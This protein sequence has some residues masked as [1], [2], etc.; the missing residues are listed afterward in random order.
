MDTTQTQSTGERLGTD[1]LGR[2][3]HRC[4]DCGTTEGAPYT[5]NLDG[6]H[7]CNVCVHLHDAEHACL[8]EAAQRILDAL[9]NLVQQA[10]HYMPDNSG[11]LMHAK[12]V[13]AEVRGKLEA[14]RARHAKDTGVDGE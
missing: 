4:A 7:R 10:S 3:I 1:S 13:L 12:A 9:G 2:A 8:D 6:K 11:P 14:I 5:L